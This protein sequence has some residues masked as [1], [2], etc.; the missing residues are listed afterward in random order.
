MFKS[1]TLSAC[2]FSI[3][4]T[5]VAAPASAPLGS[6]VFSF[7]RTFS[8]SISNASAILGAIESLVKFSFLKCD[9]IEFKS[10]STL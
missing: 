8:T 4:L 3:L 5:N 9:L 1:L 6:F 2:S 10:K 7:L